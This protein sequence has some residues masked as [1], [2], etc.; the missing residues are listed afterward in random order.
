[1][2]AEQHLDEGGD[3]LVELL[4]L[5]F[6]VVHIKLGD[7]EECLL[8]ILTQERGDSCQH[9]IGQNT[10]TPK[11]MVM[12]HSAQDSGQLDREKPSKSKSHISNYRNK[13]WYYSK[14]ENEEMYN[15]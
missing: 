12:G 5:L 7:V 2:F 8:L 14:S 9:H 15:Q 3:S 1:M 6:M 13:Q 10:N 11:H 4:Q